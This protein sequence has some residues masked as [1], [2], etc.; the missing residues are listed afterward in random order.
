MAN[1]YNVLKIDELTRI[2]DAGGIERYYRHQIKTKGG[3]IL[4]V[5]I[6]KKDFTGELAAPILLKE[7]QNADKILAL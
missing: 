2:S 3:V 6:S 4:T 5:D 1:E 7:A